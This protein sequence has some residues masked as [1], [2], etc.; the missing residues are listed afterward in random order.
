MG[1]N[2]IIKMIV[3]M[4]DASKDDS[5]DAAGALDQ[6]IISYV[7]GYQDALKTVLDNIRILDMNKEVE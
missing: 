6:T 7:N 4:Y 2:E 5:L 1:K 3:K